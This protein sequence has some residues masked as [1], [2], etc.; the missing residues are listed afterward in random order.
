M[1]VAKR[2]FGRSLDALTAAVE[3]VPKMEVVAGY[4]GDEGRKPVEGSEDITMAELAIIHEYG[5]ASKAGQQTHTPGWRIPP[6]PF[7]GDAVKESGKR[8][9][10]RMEA[11]ISEVLE[12]AWNGRQKF[13][14]QLRILGLDMKSA[15][16]TKIPYWRVPNAP[17]TIEKK[18]SS[19]PLRDLGPLGTFVRARASDGETDKVVS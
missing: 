10:A 16:Q 2:A 8:W 7:F 6:R 11:A 14:N 1:T 3:R 4:F 17:S 19:G 5:V 13:P 9:Q 12:D 15:I 18:G